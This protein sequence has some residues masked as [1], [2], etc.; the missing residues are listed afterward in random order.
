[1]PSLL[2][3]HLN[4]SLYKDLNMKNKEKRSIDKNEVPEHLKDIQFVDDLLLEGEPRTKGYIPDYGK[5]D[6]DLIES[7]DDFRQLFPE[8][9]EAMKRRT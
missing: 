4:I 7:F 8:T 1:M 2:N 5:P 3:N 9:S 6:F